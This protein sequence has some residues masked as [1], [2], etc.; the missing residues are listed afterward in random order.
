MLF[1]ERFF[2]NI[3]LDPCASIFRN[4][5][6]TDFCCISTLQLRGSLELTCKSQ[7]EKLK[8]LN[9]EKRIKRDNLAEL[10]ESSWKD[11]FFESI[12]G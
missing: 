8:V 2:S 6:T 11:N 4:Q 9:T 7:E 12:R 10:A 3:M 5:N 1:A